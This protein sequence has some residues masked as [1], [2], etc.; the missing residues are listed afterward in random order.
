M[1]DLDIPETVT[2]PFVVATA[3]PLDD[4]VAAARSRV[5]PLAAGLLEAERVRI[6]TRPAGESGFADL[7]TA[8]AWVRPDERHLLDKADQ[9]I[10]VTG[11]IPP[12]S[13]PGHGQ[14]LREVARVIAGC[15]D[16]LVYDAWSHQVLA[17]DFRFAAERPDFCLADDWLAVF[18]SGGGDGLRL[19]TAG[20]HRFAMA[21]L[22]AA[23]V[24]TDNLFAAVT[25]LRCLAVALLAEHWDWLACH[26]GERRRRLEQA[27]RADGRD[28]WRYWAVEPRDAG[29]VRVRLQ[30]SDGGRHDGLSY[31]TVTPPADFD[32]TVATWWNDVVDLAMPFV[33]ETPRHLPA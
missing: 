3:H 33:P 12:V 1:I 29:R 30:P 4:P 23:D 15:C 21:E 14:A 9:H 18:I 26:P 27:A 25:L 17:H 20:L 32:A 22:E 8:A 16:G 19:V 5:R 28:I 31:L 6:R 11:S 13:Q 24:P 7:L 2:T 10:V